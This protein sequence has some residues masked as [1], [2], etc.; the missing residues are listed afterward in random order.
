MDPIID[1]NKLDTGSPNTIAILD[2]SFYPMGFNIV[3]PTM[4]VTVPGFPSV[5]IPF[6][7]GS[8]Q[9]YNS[10]TLGISC[11]SC[12]NI[13]LPD[14]IYTFRYSITPSYQYYVEKT[15]LRVDQ[16]LQ[17]FDEL[18]LKMEFTKCDDKIKREDELLLD[19]IETYIEG[20]I[21]CA[22]NCL[23]K[24]ALELY[25]KVEKLIKEYEKTNEIP[26]LFYY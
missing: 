13:P 24:R 3:S 7:A 18:F 26:K 12:P 20:A 2:T 10:S 5:I 15:Y 21:A 8:L 16:L 22:N 1:I 19:T 11:Q 9:V 6:T 17:K 23:N 14:G 25:H 4:Q